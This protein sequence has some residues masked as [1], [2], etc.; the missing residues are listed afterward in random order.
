MKYLLNQNIGNNSTIN[1]ENYKINEK[2]TNVDN[3]LKN[4]K[5]KSNNANENYNLNKSNFLKKNKSC[6][7]LSTKNFNDSKLKI[8]ENDSKLQI[9]KNMIR[10]RHSSFMNQSLYY[11]NKSRNKV[12]FLNEN[13][14]NV[15]ST[16]YSNFPLIKSKK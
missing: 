14:I 5:I 16:N 3:L 12:S 8:K 2:S 10:N 11:N 1:Y 13:K 7:N 15:S 6:M 9:K 4:Y